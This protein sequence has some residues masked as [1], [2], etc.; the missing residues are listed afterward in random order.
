MSLPKK[1]VLMRKGIDDIGYQ[2]QMEA[3]DSLVPGSTGNKAVLR[4][5]E[6]ASARHAKKILTNQLRE[7]EEDLLIHR[8]VYPVYPAKVEYSLTEHGKSIIPILE[9][10]KKSGATTTSSLSSATRWRSRTR[11]GSRLPS[12]LNLRRS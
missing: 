2:R 6:D 4:A 1:N 9:M 3:N 10:M 8:E 11:T 7:L 12:S 5:E